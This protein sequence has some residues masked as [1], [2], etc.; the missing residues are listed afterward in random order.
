MARLRP[1][2]GT[3]RAAAAPMRSPAWPTCVTRAVISEEE[4]QRGK[5]K[6]LA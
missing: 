6:A 2:C 3:P 1:E 4:F 5:P